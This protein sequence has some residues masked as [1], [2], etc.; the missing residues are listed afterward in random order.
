MEGGSLNNYMALN[1]LIT[2]I[3]CTKLMKNILNGLA[4]LHKFNIIHRDIKPGYSFL[5]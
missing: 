5:H 1:P 2:E 4:Y 3:I